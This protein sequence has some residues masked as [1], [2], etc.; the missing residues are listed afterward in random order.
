MLTDPSIV[1]R[2]LALIQSDPVAS[3]FL[4][5][6]FTNWHACLHVRSARAQE[7]SPTL[8][9]AQQIAYDL[10]GLLAVAYRTDWQADLVS[11]GIL[12]PGL[13]REFLGADVE[14]FHV[15][16]RA[17]FDHVA[18]AIRSMAARPQV[19]PETF[20]RL[21][22][23]VERD[24]RAS[25]Q[26]SPGLISLVGNCLWF[27]ELRRVRD[28]ITHGD[29][30][31]VG[32]IFNDRPCFQILAGSGLAVLHPRLMANANIVDFRLYVAAAFAELLPFLDSLGTLGIEH[33][34]AS[35]DCLNARLMH[36]GLPSARAWLTR[37]A[38]HLSEAAV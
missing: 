37:L 23:W 34:E 20:E 13:W 14:H 28:L 22:N 27:G 35:G 1:A 15:L 9:H 32:F 33:L 3:C 16:F 6:G 36:Y 7:Q 25:A 2:S 12:P 8:V 24:S 17:L 10:W 30:L 21:R 29:S 4:E 19:L 11:R 38:T 26:L 5:D 31:T 18:A